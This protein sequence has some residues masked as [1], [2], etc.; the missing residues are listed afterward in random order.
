MQYAVIFLACSIVFTLG[1]FIFYLWAKRQQRIVQRYNAQEFAN[2]TELD[3]LAPSPPTPSLLAPQAASTP[4]PLNLDHI[5]RNRL[6][7]ENECEFF[8]RL[9][10]ALPHYHICTQ[11]AFSALLKPASGITNSEYFSILGRYSRK[12]ADFVVCEPATMDVIAIIELDD[13][14]HR[15]KDDDQRDELLHAAGYSI[16]RYPSHQ[17]PSVEE[18][19]MV[20]KMNHAEAV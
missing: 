4:R 11:V 12:R 15:K 9:R 2:A 20:F 8:Q 18:L 7:T 10:T 5:A 16:Y 14:T 13:R 1:C 3:A 17:K 19:R 6:V